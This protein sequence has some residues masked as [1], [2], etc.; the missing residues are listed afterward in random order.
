[1]ISVRVLIAVAGIFGAAGVGL[2]AV[3]A[4]RADLTGLGTAAN[5]LL[6]HAPAFLALGLAPGNR[7]RMIASFVLMAGLMLFNGDLLTRAFFDHRL[8]PMAAPSGGMLMIAG[9]L[10]IAISAFAGKRD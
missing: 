8:F 9:W 4:H 7:P 5:M 10:G 2:S 3:A 1:L 6:L